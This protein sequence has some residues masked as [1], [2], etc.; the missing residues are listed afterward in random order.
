MGD[1]WVM[2]ARLALFT[3][4]SDG[5]DPRFAEA[6]AALATELARRGIGVVYGGG[7]VGLMGVVADAALAAGGEV[8]GVIP[9]RLVDAEVAHAGLSRLEV[10][11]DMHARKARMAELAD[12]FVALPGGL[13]TLEEIFEV[14]TWQQLGYHRDPV[15]LY[16][17]AG[18]WASLLTTLD[19]LRDAGFVGAAARSSLVVADDPETLLTRLEGWRPPPLRFAGAGR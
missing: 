3:G 13:G 10:V 15:C 7:R 4:S 16:D 2:I 11:P 8:V 1:S 9:E 6:V 14:W 12:G 5:T 18:F 19:G 17:V